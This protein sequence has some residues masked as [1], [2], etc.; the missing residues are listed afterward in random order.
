MLHLLLLCWSLAC[1][2]LCDAFCRNLY[3]RSNCTLGWVLK[4]S[5]SGTAAREYSYGRGDFSIVYRTVNGTAVR[6]LT[7]WRGGRPFNGGQWVGCDW[8]TSTHVVVAC[9]SPRLLHSF[10][11]FCL[12]F[13]INT[14][15]TQVDDRFKYP[16]TRVPSD[17]DSTLSGVY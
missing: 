9:P 11:W 10:C 16:A 1:L 2:L 7:D 4:S 8:R 6:P 12:S 5:D 15:R 3:P 14:H 17:S 13:F